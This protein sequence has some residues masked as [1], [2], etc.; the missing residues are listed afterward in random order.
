M[1]GHSISSRSNRGALRSNL[2]AAAATTNIG[3]SKRQGARLL[4][5]LVAT[6]AHLF[7]TLN[8]A[9]S[10]TQYVHKT[11]QSDAGLPVNSVLSIA[12]TADGYVWLGT[13]EGLVRFDG[14]RFTTFEK[15][16]TP[17]L[18]SN[19]I[20]TLL[21]DH[22]QNLWIG[23]RGGGLSRFSAGH[24]S[25]FTSPVLSS[26][27]SILSLYE[28][29]QGALWIGTDGQGL[30]RYDHGQFRTFRK[31]DGL[32]DN[33]VFAIAGG[34]GGDV[35]LGTH[36]GLCHFFRG[37]FDTFTAR[38]GL[39]SNFV[40]AALVDASGTVWAGTDGGGLVSIRDGNLER[41]THAN[42]LSEDT[43]SALYEDSAGTL[44][45]GTLNAGLNRLSQ[46][47]FSGFGEKEGFSG[48][49]IQAITEDRDG[50]LWL[51]TT[52]G[53]VQYLAQGLFSTVSKQ[54]GL[55]SDVALGVFEDG[56]HALW[57]GSDQGLNRIENG[58]ITTYTTAQGLPDNLVFS[59][60]QD[61]TGA[62][63]AGTRRG[64]ARLNRQTIT[65]Y[66]SKAGLP[67]D[68]V[69]C[70]YM[71]RKGDL[72][73][74]T[75][76]GLSHFDGKRF[77][78]YTTRDGLTG[79]FV[80]SL[81]QDA[82][83]TLWVGTNGAGLN[84]FRDGRTIP[85]AGQSSFQN[86]TIWSIAGDPDATLWIATNGAG[87]KRLKNGQVT[88]YTTAEGLF[89]NVVLSVVD[90]RLGHL[91][92]S[93]NKGV[94]AVDKQQLNDFAEGRRKSIQSAVYGT[95]DGM[96]SRECNGGFQP[97]A[98]RMHDGRLV[99]PTMKGISIIDPAR[100]S[101]EPVPLPPIIERLLANNKEVDYARTIEISP[102][103]RNVNIDFTSPDFQSPEKIHFR[104]M[105]EGF[106]REWINADS[107]RAYYTNL[108][109]GRYTFRVLAC[110][111]RGVCS[112]N[113]H[114]PILTVEPAFYESRP[115]LLLLLALAFS[116]IWGAY[117][118]R[119]RHLKVREQKLVALVDERTQQLRESRDQLEVR[120]EERTRELVHLNR[121]LEAEVKVR[122]QA[123]E[124]AEAASQ[125][126]SDFLANMSHE[127]R[128]PINGIMGMADIAL[129]SDP[130][131]EQAEYLTI[132]RNS[133]E[134]LMDVVNAILDFSKM[135][136]GR[137]TLEEI[138]FALAAL[139]DELRTLVSFRAQQKNL[140]LH[141][142]A[143]PA[144][145]G[146][147]IGDPTR[148][149]QILLNLLDN[150]LKFT[151]EGSITLRA[152]VEVLSGQDVVLHFTVTDTG[153]GIPKEKFSSIF[154]AF[155]QAD[156]SSTRRFGGTG[157][158]LSISSQL[159]SLMQGR[160]W[161]ESI[162]GQGS[163]FHVIARFKTLQPGAAEPSS[164]VG[165]TSS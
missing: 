45:V 55:S 128:T 99:F 50:N 97:S 120:V 84:A 42:G 20:W 161:V 73:A 118:L 33:S 108:P 40:R 32:P 145:P 156:N 75:R 158:G 47:R 67:S 54:E 155:N 132:I 157:L 23:T 102:G 144:I 160:I 11:W 101:G 7:A 35:W 74:G 151:P 150:A 142:E 41:Y 109:P 146:T 14:V 13:E 37:S 141:L 17:G 69:I 124:E 78:T 53:G 81:Y 76:A 4:V 39:G 94:F 10:I 60:A 24:F 149:R 98:W 51:G 92:M 93:S 59:S 27:E 56:G 43:V 119:L 138:P 12:Q 91:W 48:G 106:D 154:E 79:N 152:G 135:E 162:V 80:Q 117:R 46:G 77:S 100:L 159:A 123:E 38:D 1:T 30:L 70:T 89:Q 65:E 133:V 110:N 83:G 22:Q 19:Q 58:H 153:I 36:A 105:L 34:A 5:L 72:W 137:F 82:S 62:I 111:D 52:E 107:R 26:T 31:Q 131:E 86:Q 2:P 148:L 95:A 140:A 139:L 18:G 163:T 127:I 15:G 87:L 85:F 134:S 9:E 28:D 112:S 44:W 68:F 143:S 103:K 63:W 90:D 3:V 115:F 164:L 25:Q 104:Y 126:K 116:G 165:A 16:I 61:S 66:N 49:G 147:L 113:Q 6:A 71:D 88:S 136:A 29:K 21:V 130:P 57:V 114:L 129:M 64:L 121:S 8:P 96:K 125:A 122:R